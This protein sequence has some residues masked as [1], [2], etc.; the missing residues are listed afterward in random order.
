MSTQVPDTASTRA[1]ERLIWWLTGVLAVWYMAYALVVGPLRSDDSVWYER[2]GE[3]FLAYWRDPRAYLEAVSYHGAVPLFYL[4]FTA[5]VGVARELFGPHGALVITVLNAVALACAAHLVLRT[6]FRLTH[7]RLPVVVAAVF[8][9]ACYE[10][11]MWVPFVLSDSTF[12]LLVTLVLCLAILAQRDDR[13]DTRRLAAACGIALIAPLYRPTG[14][15]LIGWL[16]AAGAL[17][18]VWRQ[19][20]ALRR[21]AQV[22]TLGLLGLAVAGLLAVLLGLL[23]AAPPAEAPP[24]LASMLEVVR[25]ALTS[26]VVVDAR[27]E[28]YVPLVDTPLDIVRLI[29]KRV[30]YFFVFWADGF[31]TRHV[32]ANAVVYVP[33]YLLALVAVVAVLG[34]RG[35]TTL[36][37][38]RAV[39]LT[40]VLISG[41]ALMHGV[42]F[43][44][45]DWRYRL[46]VYPALFLLAALGAQHV[47]TIARNR[48]IIRFSGSVSRHA[49]VASTS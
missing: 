17:H 48:G 28:T 10:Q 46:P 8:F 18:P 11:L 35:A 32:I 27:P 13:I 6:L 2:A 37:E 7:S 16:L 22:R 24:L 34:R 29:G 15:W 4:G 25:P 1:G 26:G 20:S 45:F 39:V 40:L 41:F 36:A 49:R 47:A 3:L 43:V 31:S 44:D 30:I 21:A 5:L 9:A 42:T 23:V 38:Q 33:S 19:P 12:A 14:V